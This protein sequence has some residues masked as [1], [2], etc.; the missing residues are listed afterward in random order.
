VQMRDAA[1]L[2]YVIDRNT[3]SAWALMKGPDI[4]AR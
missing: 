1:D 2:E 4:L 3:N